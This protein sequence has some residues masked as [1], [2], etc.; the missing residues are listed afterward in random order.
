MRRLSPQEKLIRCIHAMATV[1]LL[2]SGVKRLEKEVS[3]LG[4]NVIESNLGLCRF[5]FLL[6]L[7]LQ[8]GLPV[9][10]EALLLKLV[11]VYVEHVGE[12]P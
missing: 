9:L 6:L 11:G 1:H 8:N 10:V 3:S 7:L 12:P 2:H 4:M 5:P